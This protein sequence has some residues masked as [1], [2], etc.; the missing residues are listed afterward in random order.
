MELLRE[1]DVPISDFDRVFRH[2]RIVAVLVFGLWA[3]AGVLIYRW[4]THAHETAFRIAGI[5]IL[6]T[7]LLYRDFL[8]ARFRP[9]NWLIRSARSGL[10]LKFR[11]YLNYQLSPD[12]LTVAFIPYSEIS[13][14]WRMTE[15]RV[16]PS[17][18]RG[19]SYDRRH[20]AELEVRCDTTLLDAA[21]AE[22]RR[23]EGPWVRHWYGRSRHKQHDEHIAVVE[24]TR[25][26]ISFDSGVL[27]LQSF[28]DSLPS[29][30][31]IRE[32]VIEKWSADLKSLSREE[33][34]RRMT[35][36][37]RS[38]RPFEAQRIAQQAY[39][40]TDSEAWRLVK[41]LRRGDVP[42]YPPEER[43][44]PPSE[45]TRNGARGATG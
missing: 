44:S 9:S 10:Y 8:L 3:P 19:T 31:T 6:L 11:S 45:Q 15:R 14:A 41:S 26:R 7:M 22:E 20:M 27:G 40:Y 36:L 18:N 35:E 4:A 28:L 34:E 21:L 38:G 5:V 32:P 16:Y 2:S 23:R 24:G 17:M 30:V 42:N 13:A 1:R 37:A 12:D 29:S 39:Y 25:V 43:L 33:L